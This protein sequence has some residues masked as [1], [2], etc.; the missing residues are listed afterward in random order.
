M[1]KVRKGRE[2]V[3]DAETKRRKERHSQQSKSRRKEGDEGKQ[4]RRESFCFPLTVSSSTASL[5]GRWLDWAA[6]LKALCGGPPVP[7]V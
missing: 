2:D 1:Q 3:N 6:A 5:P 4:G 7:G